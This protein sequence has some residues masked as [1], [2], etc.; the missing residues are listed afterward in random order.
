MTSVIIGLDPQVYG[1]SELLDRLSLYLDRSGVFSVILC[2]S[3]ATDAQENSA[4]FRHLATGVLGKTKFHL[5]PRNS[6]HSVFR[7]VKKNVLHLDY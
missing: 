7:H 5:V 4:R 2:L 6:L 3:G 1:S